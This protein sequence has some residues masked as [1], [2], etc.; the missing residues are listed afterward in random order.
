MNHPLLS[1]GAGRNMEKRCMIIGSS[2]ITLR[3]EDIEKRSP[4]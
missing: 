2:P 4:K 1:N 3:D